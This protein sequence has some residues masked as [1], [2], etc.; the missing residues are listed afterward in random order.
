MKI[1]SLNS[2][3]LFFDQYCKYGEVGVIYPCLSEINKALRNIHFKV[4]PIK[5]DIWFTKDFKRVGFY[6][7]TII[8]FDSSLSLPAA[9][10]IKAKY[11]N[12]RVIYWF[13]NH[14]Y[15]P[16]ILSKLS[17]DIEVWSYDKQDCIKYALNY[18]TQFYFDDLNTPPLSNLQRYDFCFIGKEKG[19]SEQ[20]KHC[21]DII[22][23]AGLTCK[24]IVIGN[25]R[26]DRL[27]QWIPYSEIL[28]II[29]ESRCIVDLVPVGQTGLT[30]RPMEALFHEKKLL[31]N[32]S[33]ID[34]CNFYNPDNIR[35]IS[36]I[37][38]TELKKFIL[39]PYQKI[40]P[41]II[42]YYSFKNWLKRFC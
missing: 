37:N 12:L 3:V 9:N 19:R 15:D 22:R 42:R 38:A 39:T 27:R 26:K 20:I 14:I 2:G 4:L 23:Q 21:Q 25:S 32:F 29:S 8:L 1:F 11:P 34:K 36:N 6:D 30:L 28:K 13:W 5:H 18:N 40:D 35:L 16:K 17:K 24:F 31:T 7:N 41:A 10:Y 33:D